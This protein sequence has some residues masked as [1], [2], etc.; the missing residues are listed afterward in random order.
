MPFWYHWNLPTKN[1]AIKGE[2]EIT[3]EICELYLQILCLTFGFSTL[4][5]LQCATILNLSSFVTLFCA[6]FWPSSLSLLY[7]SRVLAGVA[8]SCITTNV[9]FTEVLPNDMR[10][11]FVIIESVSRSL[12]CVLTYGMGYFVGFYYH[13][14]IFGGVSTLGY[15]S[16]SSLLS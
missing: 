11:K 16:Y 6:K 13:G 2:V 12:G 10:G 7:I 5:V 15:I 1:W 4:Q 9:Y 8:R 14:A 3:F